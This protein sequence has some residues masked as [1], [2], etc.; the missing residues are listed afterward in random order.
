MADLASVLVEELGDFQVVRLAGEVDISNADQLEM[1]IS[2]VVRNDAV[3]LVLDLSG[4]EFM[5]SAGIRMLFDLR[6]RLGARRQRL[7]LAV[8]QDSLIRGSL[9]VTEVDRLLPLHATPEE[10]LESL[11][12]GEPSND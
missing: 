7:T 4:I 9:V 12:S 6:T 5:D 2:G 8:P 10:G 11:R 3:G 1:E